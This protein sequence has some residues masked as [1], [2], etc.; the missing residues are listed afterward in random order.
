[1][2]RRLPIAMAALLLWSGGAL[3]QADKFE[4][5]PPAPAGYGADGTLIQ[6]CNENDVQAALRECQSKIRSYETAI[7]DFERRKARKETDATS[8]QLQWLR[9][10]QHDLTRY[11]DACAKIDYG[12]QQ[13][14][15]HP[16]TRC[17]ANG[18]RLR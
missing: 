3:A 13:L 12:L 8:R 14:R 10:M 9:G 11:K 6:M 17:D 7:R 1:M 16:E 2:P 5:Q 4:D 15:A 18:Q